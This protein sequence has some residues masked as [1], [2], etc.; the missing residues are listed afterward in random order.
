MATGGGGAG[1][2]MVGGSISRYG[3]DS[4]LEKQL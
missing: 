1:C 3:L 2:A 4:R